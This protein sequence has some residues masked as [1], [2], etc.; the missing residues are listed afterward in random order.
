VSDVTSGSAA[1]VDEVI[2]PPLGLVILKVAGRCN[3]NCSYCYEFNLA[4]HQL[5]AQ[6]RFMSDEVFDA[7][8]R[9]V[10]RHVEKSGQKRIGLSFHGGEPTLVGP[11]RF[12]SWC[13]RAESML[14]GIDVRFAM[15]TNGTLLTERWVDVL[16]RHEVDVGISLDGPREVN[17]MFRVDH[18]GRGSHGKVVQG[19]KL[20]QAAG[21]A[22][23][24]LSVIQL[25]ADPIVIH[26][27]FLD[28]GCS[29]ISY[30]MPDYTHDTIGDVRARYGPA[31]CADFLIPI[32]DDWWFNSTIE[33]RV[34]N[35]WEVSRL[36]LGGKSR[37][38][39]LGNIP[40]GFVIVNPSGDIEGLDVLKACEDGLTQTGLNVKS[41]D[42]VS[43]RSRSPMH[44]QMVF[45]G[46][47]LPTG[48]TDCVERS[49]CAGGYHPHRYSRAN[50]FDNRSV[51]CE[52]LLRIFGHIRARL[53]VAA[54][55]TVKLRTEQ[56]VA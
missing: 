5:K 32:F 12:A 29:S 19:I 13:A 42:F 34:R 35:F 43:L 26:R 31:P 7:T 2:V 49:T 40:L 8:L 20:L 1:V 22:P 21:R 39:A 23:G 47:P 25:G 28:I 37:I 55:D 9:C 24:I 10:A 6:P 50:G 11:D 45:E 44:A 46:A 51:W 16:L 36:I 41:D 3:L 56:L 48:C 30:L 53:G 17:D 52:D 14:S 54:N 18:A 15:Q 38:D 33:V 4:D 27:H